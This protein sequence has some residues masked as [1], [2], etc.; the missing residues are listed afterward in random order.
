MLGEN[1]CILV[2]NFLD[3]N[4]CTAT[5]TLTSFRGALWKLGH[6]MGVG[7]T[8]LLWQCHL[9]QPKVLVKLWPG[10]QVNSLLKCLFT[11]LLGAFPSQLY[12][13]WHAQ[14]P[15]Q[16]Q[17]CAAASEFQAAWLAHRSGRWVE[18]SEVAPIVQDA[19][20]SYPHLCSLKQWKDIPHSLIVLL[21]WLWWFF[22]FFFFHNGW[23]M[24]MKPLH[25]CN[26]IQ[27]K[28]NGQGIN[29]SWSI[30]PGKAWFSASKGCMRQRAVL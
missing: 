20:F 29:F 17:S 12:S 13:T 18:S 2:D 24:G 9:K 26:S 10:V 7:R 22:P 25:K 30:F 23:F 19:E 1:S 6:E 8:Y 3:W 5:W 21:K 4:V 27:G 11:S 28:E 14:G 16:R 15:T